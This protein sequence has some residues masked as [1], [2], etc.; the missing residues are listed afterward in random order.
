MYEFDWSSIVPSLPYLLD[1]LVITLSVFVF[2]EIWAFVYGL[3]YTVI[4]SLAI[5][6][7]TKILQR[8]ILRGE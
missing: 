1:G 5:D 8:T 4:T 3:V 2:R 7:T 6:G